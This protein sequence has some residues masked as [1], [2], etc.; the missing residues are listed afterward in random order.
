MGLVI[1]ER[2]TKHIFR[3]QVHTSKFLSEEWEVMKLALPGSIQT[4]VATG[5]SG[6]ID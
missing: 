6:H 4:Q 3:A 1:K 5:F 2:T